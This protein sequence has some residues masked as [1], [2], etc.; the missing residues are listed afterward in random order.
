MKTCLTILAAERHVPA[1][2]VQSFQS[3]ADGDAPKTKPGVGGY[4]E[5][6]P[7]TAYEGYR[8]LKEEEEKRKAENK[9]TLKQFIETR[10]AAYNRMIAEIEN[11]AMNDFDSPILITGPT[12]AGK[13]TL[14]KKIKEIREI[15]FKSD[16]DRKKHHCKTFK[17]ENCALLQGDLVESTLFGH[18]EGAFTDAKTQMKGLIEC[19]EGGILFLDE[20][21]SLPLETQAKLLTV[22]DGTPF[23]RKGSNDE[24]KRVVP[25]FQLFCGTNEDLFKKVID[26]SF[27][28][29]LW[30]RIATWHFD[31]P[32][33]KDRPEDIEPNIMEEMKRA[34]KAIEHEKRFQGQ[35]LDEF[36]EYVKSIPIE[37]NF[38]ELHRMVL[39][40]AVLAKGDEITSSDV[41][42]EINRHKKESEGFSSANDATGT[43]S[44]GFVE[45]SNPTSERE[46]DNKDGLGWLDYGKR[47]WLRTKHPLD[48][49]QLVEVVRVC[50]QSKNA[51]EAGRKLFP[52]LKDKKTNPSSYI[53][54]FFRKKCFRDLEI[55]FA[56]IPLT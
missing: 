31:L 9:Q 52:S 46:D 3:S 44:S 22:L 6:D 15:R 12:G 2:L 23:N 7:N 50:R 24:D 48:Y 37:G 49:L 41:R 45:K 18:E 5:T 29:D 42:E 36:V 19:A 43:D 51:A 26:G 53:G 11:V 32:G 28:R 30:E 56:G 1:K 8:K 35:P 16:A 14:V 38:R 54:Q 4:S 10:N 55:T 34:N 47:E 39:R 27:R 40:M 20:I 17:H 25:N 21:G 33:L 13:S